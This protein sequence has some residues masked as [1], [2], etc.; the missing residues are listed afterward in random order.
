VLEIARHESSIIE[1]AT[2][3]ILML[4][5]GHFHVISE[6]WSIWLAVASGLGVLVTTGFAFARAEKLGPLATFVIVA[7]NLGLGLLLVGLKLWVSH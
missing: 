4:L 2:I 1:A 3:P 5:L 6:Q 7:I